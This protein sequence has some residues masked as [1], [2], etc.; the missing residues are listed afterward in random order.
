MSFIG[1]DSYILKIILFIH[2]NCG[3]SSIFTSYSSIAEMKDPLGTNRGACSK[4]SCKE[5]RIEAKAVRPTCWYCECPAPAH[6]ELPGNLIIFLTI[7][8]AAEKK[9]RSTNHLS[10]CFHLLYVTDDGSSVL[11]FNVPSSAVLMSPSGVSVPTMSSSP[12]T[13]PNASLLSSSS[14]ESGVNFEKHYC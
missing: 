14:S 5:Y 10:N 7:I 1:Y 2:I 9:C 3:C 6:A 4:C 13:S 8:Y 12:M 11:P